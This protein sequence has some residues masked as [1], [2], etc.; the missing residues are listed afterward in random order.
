MVNEEEIAQ[1]LE[2]VVSKLH[3]CDYESKIQIELHVIKVFSI[4]IQF[5]RNQVNC[6]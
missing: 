4:C 6:T 3:K 5:F 2:M 1:S